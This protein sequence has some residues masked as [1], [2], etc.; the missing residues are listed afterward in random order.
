[1]QCHCAAQHESTSRQRDLTEPIAV[2]T[3]IEKDDMTMAYDNVILARRL[4]AEYLLGTLA[5]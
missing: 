1:L 2:P 4:L 3:E 5:A